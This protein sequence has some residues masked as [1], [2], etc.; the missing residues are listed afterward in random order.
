MQ[1][2]IAEFPQG[3]ES[4]LVI[5][6]A[7]APGTDDPALSDL[8]PDMVQRVTN[9]N[10]GRRR[11]LSDEEVTG[12]QRAAGSAG[13]RLWLISEPSGVAAVADIL[14]QSDRIRFLTPLLHHQM[15]Q[16]LKW[17]GRDDTALGIDVDSLG[18]DAADLAKLAVSSRADV[19]AQIASWDGG[20]A[21]GDSTRERVNASSAV[22]VLTVPGDSPLHYLRGGMAME[23]LWV[24]AG[25]HHL[26]L[27]PVSPVFLFA[28]SDAD[29]TGL[30]PRFSAD[31]RAL[32]RRFNRTVGLDDAD[33]AVLVMRL[34]HGAPPPAVRSR[35][36]DRDVVVTTVDAPR[37]EGERSL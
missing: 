14:A 19:M 37:G 23:R 16:E 7:L 17:P 29:L 20:V 13:A 22:A 27:A 30:S 34:S 36:L 2:S 8:Y 6:I 28:R 32:Q 9:R 24:Q 15:M 33:A 3:P 18:L 5:S 31:L 4:D 1:A 12:L 35:R 25:R 26:A 10:V 11:A 21:L